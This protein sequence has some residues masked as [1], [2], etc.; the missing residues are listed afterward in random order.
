MST[1]ALGLVCLATACSGGGARFA[2]TDPNTAAAERRAPGVAVDPI[3]RQPPGSPSGSSSDG[4][5]VLTAPLGAEHVEHGVARFFDALLQESGEALDSVVSEQAYLESPAGRQPAR[6]ALRARFAQLDYS[7]LR[8]V[9]VYRERDLEVYQAEDAE[10]LAQT[11]Q[12]PE[13]LARDQVF[14][15]VHVLVSHA[16]KTRLLSDEM[17]L[18][19]RRE[20]DGYRIWAIR[21]SAPTP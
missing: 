11:R 1:G 8:G 14:V 3:S 13:D 17:G 9:N 20:R 2:T 15:R 5:L 18:S 12:L 10:K 7:T 21:E 6:G 16:G 19:L 4:L